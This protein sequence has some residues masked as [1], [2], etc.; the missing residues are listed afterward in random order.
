MS[1]NYFVILNTQDG[2]IAPLVIDDGELAVF[3]SETEAKLAGEGN[4]LGANF[5]FEVFESGTGIEG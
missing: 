3:E 1:E 5:G 2:G 4:L